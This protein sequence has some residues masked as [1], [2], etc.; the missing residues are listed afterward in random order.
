MQKFSIK[1]TALGVAVAMAAVA[2]ASV[3][4]E[5]RFLLSFPAV[6]LFWFKLLRCS[7]G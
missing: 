4:P 3:E 2:A 5:R 6:R 7:R 1:A